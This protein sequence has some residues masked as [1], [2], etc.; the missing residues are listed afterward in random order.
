[1]KNSVWPR[2]FTRIRSNKVQSQ[3]RHC[4][5]DKKIFKQYPL[6]GKVFCGCCEHAMPRL[7]KKE[8]VFTCRHSNIDQSMECHGLQIA[9]NELEELLFQVISKQAELILK[10]DNVVSLKE[11]DVQLAKKSEYDKLV[12]EYGEQKRL[13]YERFLTQEIS[14]DEYRV[15]KAVYDEEIGDLN[16]VLSSMTADIA[17]IGMGNAEMTKLQRY[18][19]KVILPLH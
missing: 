14:L 5:S 18:I 15:Q 13:L 16:R 10:T 3:L 2:L 19:R 17:H 9:E 8:P 4:K 12:R 11:Y 7:A 1:M 6:K